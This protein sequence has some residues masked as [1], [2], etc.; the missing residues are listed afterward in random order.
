MIL[1]VTFCWCSVMSVAWCCSRSLQWQ[2]RKWQTTGVHNSLLWVI[3]LKQHPAYN[4][5]GT[6]LSNW[7]WCCSY[8]NVNISLCRLNM[9]KHLKV[10]N[11]S[12]VYWA[13]LGRT[14][15][16][17]QRSGL[18]LTNWLSVRPYIIEDRQ[19]QAMCQECYLQR[20]LGLIYQH[21]P[22]TG[23]DDPLVV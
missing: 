5:R 3:H 11:I 13:S 9:H 1:T 18:K 6:T 7:W 16:L 17:T 23:R 14:T 20:K 4:S 10:T 19:C 21:L 8:K 12:D 15:S 2:H 22:L